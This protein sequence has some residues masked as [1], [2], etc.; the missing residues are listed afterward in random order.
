MPPNTTM[1]SYHM[2]STSTTWHGSS[3][4]RVSRT[5]GRKSIFA[6]PI[7]TCAALSANF[8]GFRLIRFRSDHP[9]GGLRSLHG[10]GSPSA[11][12]YPYTDW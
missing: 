12:R 1:C 8:S 9:G 5:A 3:P 6:A 7:P 11:G 4:T 10:H 2:S